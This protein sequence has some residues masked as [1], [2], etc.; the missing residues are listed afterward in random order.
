MD[1]YY[2]V[3]KVILATNG[4]DTEYIV[5]KEY[6][7]PLSMAFLTICEDYNENECAHY[8]ISQVHKTNNT[9][10]EILIEKVYCGEIE[11]MIK[12]IKNIKEKVA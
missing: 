8:E 7:I 12:G 11:M 9:K 5:I 3:T 6:I 10:S 1:R 2:K 4:E